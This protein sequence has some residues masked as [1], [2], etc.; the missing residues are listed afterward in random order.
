[1]RYRHLWWLLPILLLLTACAIQPENARTDPV[2][3]YYCSAQQTYGD[4]TG[5][6]AVES[7]QRG[8]ALLSPRICR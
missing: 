1:M 7:H 5:T 2:D 6:L 4:S 8:F 3:F